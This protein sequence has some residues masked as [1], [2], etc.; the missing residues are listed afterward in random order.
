[1]HTMKSLP[2]ITNALSAS[3]ATDLGSQE[4]VRQTVF[5]SNG[6]IEVS[7]EYEARLRLHRRENVY[8]AH[9]RQMMY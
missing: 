6:A 5:Q 2:K 3:N 4:M 9:I 7:E 1:M 8:R